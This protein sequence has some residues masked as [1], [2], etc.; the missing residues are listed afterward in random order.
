MSARDNQM[1]A[2]YRSEAGI[3][4]ALVKPVEA[5]RTV[6]ELCKLIGVAC[7]KVELRA[8]GTRSMYNPLGYR[9]RILPRGNGL[10]PMDCVLHELAH[11][12]VYIRFGG[13]KSGIQDHGPE[14]ARTEAAL[15]TL[16][17]LDRWGRVF[18]QFDENG[19]KLY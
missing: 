13:K 4:G 15:F 3:S 11:H 5:R 19:V 7:P 18:R 1:S 9:L 10:M 14:F 12:I 2:V 6:R 16:M 8:G 17:N